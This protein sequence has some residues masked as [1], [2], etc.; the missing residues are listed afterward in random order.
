MDLVHSIAI[1]MR[2]VTP[3]RQPHFYI[4]NFSNFPR[5]ARHPSHAIHGAVRHFIAKK[6]ETMASLPRKTNI[7][8]IMAANGN[9]DNY[10]N[11]QSK[12]ARTEESLRS[13]DSP[14]VDG[15]HPTMAMTATPPRSKDDGIGKE[16]RI[17]QDYISRK[18]H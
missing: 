16:V 8:G 17:Y 1:K 14:F 4:L 12:K 11:E 10:H 3:S 9:D 5:A 18:P 15:I 13:S 6:V 2:H 7:I